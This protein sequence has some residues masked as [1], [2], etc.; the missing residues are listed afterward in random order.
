[1]HSMQII[2]S[3]ILF[4]FFS[5]VMHCLILL[6]FTII[7]IIIMRFLLSILFYNDF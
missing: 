3:Y 6:L 5:D 2:F 7:I 1:M 4:L